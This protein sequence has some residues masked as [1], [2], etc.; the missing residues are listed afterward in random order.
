MSDK[1]TNKLVELKD[2][3]KSQ[4]L[5]DALKA[6]K[7]KRRRSGE[8]KDIKVDTK[9]VEDRKTQKRME[10]KLRNDKTFRDKALRSNKRDAT[11]ERK[12]RVTDKW[13]GRNYDRAVKDASN[14]SE[15]VGTKKRGA[16]F[17][18]QM[19][20]RKEAG[21]RKLMN[22][23]TKMKKSLREKLEDLKK[24]MRNG[25]LGGPGSV[26]AGAV[27]PSVTN[28]APKPG[29]NSLSSKMGMPGTKQ[30]SKKNPIK[31]AEQI[32]N[33]DI[34]D[35]KMKEAQAALKAKNPQMVVK[36][37]K[38]GQW[39]MVKME[40]ASSM[41]YD[42]ASDRV[43]DGSTVNQVHDRGTDVNIASVDRPGATIHKSNYGPKKM[44]LYSEA[45]NIKRK[46][47][48]T[49]E[50]REDVGQNKAVR[51]YTSAPMGSAK[52][53]A[54]R[55]AARDKAKSKKNPVKHMRGADI[56]Q[57][58]RDLYEKKGKPKNKKDS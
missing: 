45:D 39:S 13:Q 58:L 9:G 57:E 47:S 3:L 29:N 50:V 10:N 52:S 11:K 4:K 43:I 41:N 23:E 1:L 33:K 7:V 8:T 22:K 18:N 31:S 30:A 14:M 54:N 49:S 12:Q 42:D 20:R 51:Q 44:G 21:D 27:A 15:T 53:Q 2:M 55:E 25:G 28:N 40:Q 17:I 34:K 36:F 46:E 6:G 37:E 19:T 16:E 32:Q 38:N 26:K 35:L 56:P 5:K 48:R 24:G